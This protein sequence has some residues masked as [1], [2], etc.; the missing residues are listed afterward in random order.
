MG[1]SEK[2]SHKASSFQAEEVI[3]VQPP[4]HQLTA[5]LSL[6]MTPF[7]SL[8]PGWNSQGQKGNR[9]SSLANCGDVL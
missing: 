2:G 1:L 3:D 7:H 4:D 6:V 8:D 5:A 9:L